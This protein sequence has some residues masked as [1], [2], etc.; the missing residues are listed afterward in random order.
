MKQAVS[1]ANGA[2]NRLGMPALIRF[3]GPGGHFHEVFWQV[4][5]FDAP[6]ELKSTFPDRRGAV[7]GRAVAPRQIDHVTL[8]RMMS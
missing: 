1:A 6:A 3:R 8:S 5:R 7:V 2:R 4:E